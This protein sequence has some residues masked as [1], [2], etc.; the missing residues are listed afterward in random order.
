MIG[1]H[2]PLTLRQYTGNLDAAQCLVGADKRG[3]R[4]SGC[5][6]AS[7]EFRLAPRK[8]MAIEREPG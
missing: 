5:R 3:G 2:I 8:P 4:P 6:R 7:V 1:P